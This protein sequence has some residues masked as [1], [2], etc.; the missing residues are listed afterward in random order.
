MKN[1]FAS[2]RVSDVTIGIPVYN[3]EHFIAQAIESALGQ[4]G[5]II[6]SDNA[7]TDNTGDICLSYASRYENIVYIKHPV[8]IGSM[9]NFSYCLDCARTK[10]FMWLGAHDFIEHGYVEKL[11]NILQLNSKISF[12]YANTQY[13]DERNKEINLN[14]FNE[15]AGLR[16]RS[17]AKRI[18][19]FIENL[20]DCSMIHGLHRTSF[21]R[22]A[23]VLKKALGIDHAILCNLASFGPV[24][25]CNNK[26][27]YRR[28]MD[29]KNTVDDYMKK[30]VGDC[31]ENYSVS[32]EEMCCMQLQSIMDI[33][34][35]SII[36]KMHSVIIACSVLKK[37]FNWKPKWTCFFG[38]ARG[39]CSN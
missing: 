4:A 8:N 6:I 12:V 24:Y 22:S 15:F 16:D 7:S 1:S 3:E 18:L 14:M 2:R 38:A 17:A 39:I 37:R 10:Y 30:I 27:Y 19:S 35:I 9:S 34:D 31:M 33:K 23:M 26:K 20:V 5:Q 36:E 32:R 21:I 29:I 28:K 11:L 25:H 13:V